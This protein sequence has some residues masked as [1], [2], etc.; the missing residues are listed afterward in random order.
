MRR[1]QPAIAID[2]GTTTSLVAC[3]VNEM[4]VVLPNERGH[5]LTPSVVAFKDRQTACVGELA[6]NLLLS[7]HRKNVVIYPRKLLGTETEFKINGREYSP[8][9]IIL[10]ILRKLKNLAAEYLNV[11]EER[12]KKAILT[13]PAYFTDTQRMAILRS[14]KLAGFDLVRLVSEPVATAVAY[15]YKKTGTEERLLV[16]DLGGGSLDVT[17]METWGG[18]FYTKGHAVCKTVGGIHFDETLAHFLAAKFEKICGVNFTA[19]PVLYWNLMEVTE[20]TKIDLSFVEETEVLFPYLLTGNN[21][22]KNYLNVKV[23]RSQFQKITE[24]LFEKIRETVLKVF[25]RSS[26]V[27]GWVN[28]VIISGGTSRIPGI[29]DILLD[30]LPSGVEIENHICP[31]Q[32]VVLGGSILAGI[33]DDDEQ[34]SQLE[35]QNVTSSSFGL[36]DNDGNMVV[37]IPRGE[38]YP[39]EITRTFTTTDDN[40]EE[41]LIHVIQSRDPKNRRVFQSLGYMAVNNLPP[42]RAGEPNIRVTFSMDEYGVLTVSTEHPFKKEKASLTIKT[43]EMG[44][45]D[46]KPQRRGTGLRVV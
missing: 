15:G 37:V 36:E 27:P 44:K 45:G 43:G 35:L 18:C 7:R 24:P 6:R 28:R 22:K 10:I 16:F 23:N 11:P 39:C 29:R 26:I 38:T 31:E 34:L 42:A 8:A 30:I 14:G 2:L 21:A 4:P 41:I 32:A 25:K 20:K 5:L 12:L 1:R 17:L 19:D 9:E 13:V 40:K 3:W 46:I 33:I